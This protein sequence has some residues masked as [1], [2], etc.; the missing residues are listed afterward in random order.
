M[1]RQVS[2]MV[3]ASALRSKVFILVEGLFDWIEVW[4]VGKWA[5]RRLAN[6]RKRAHAQP[7]K[8]P[9][10]WI[11]WACKLPGRLHRVDEHLD[12]RASRL[13]WL[14][15]PSRPGI[16]TCAAKVYDNPMERRA[17][18]V[19][20]L[21]PARDNGSTLRRPEVVV[22]LPSDR[23]TGSETLPA[24]RRIHFRITPGLPARIPLPTRTCPLPS[25]APCFQAP[26][27]ARR[28]GRDRRLRG[29]TQVDALANL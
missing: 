8:A 9:S 20:L 12:R 17:P 27:Q 11:I 19:R 29:K 26:G 16:R 10:G 6:D 13:D 2:S 18:R 4:R 5:Q 3:R 25:L 22:H 24:R 28:G 23:R 15:S 14:R 1:V 7:I 21:D